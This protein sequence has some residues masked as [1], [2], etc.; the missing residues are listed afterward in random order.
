MPPTK[1]YA[2]QIKVNLGYADLAF[3]EFLP[4][5]TGKN[6]GDQIRDSIADSR[7]ALPLP[8][9]IDVESFIAKTFLPR[10]PKDERQGARET[11]REW[12]RRWYADSSKGGI[13]MKLMKASS[14]LSSRNT[15]AILT[16]AGV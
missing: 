13:G 14:T 12:T 10:L 3:L 11:L 9:R 7:L 15:D 2:R 16:A 5:R 1:K 8:P 4:K 6:V